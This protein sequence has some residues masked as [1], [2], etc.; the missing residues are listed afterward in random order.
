MNNS[1]QFAD[2]ASRSRNAYEVNPRP[3][4]ALG[5]AGPATLV[6][7]R[8]RRTM[9]MQFRPAN[10]GL[11]NRRSILRRLRL[12]LSSNNCNSP[13][14]MQELTASIHIGM[15]SH[16][17]GISKPAAYSS[18]LAAM[19]L[20]GCASAPVT[21]YHAYG[22][23]ITY[24]YSLSDP[25]TQAYPAL[26]AAHEQVS[27]VNYG[28]PGDQACDLP[29][30]QIFANK[31]NPTLATHMEYSVLVGTN[32]VIFKGT[33]AYESVFL[34]C[35]QAILSW[36]AIPAEYKTLANDTRVTT[37]GAGAINSPN[38]WNAWTTAGQGS[39]ISFPITLTRKGPIYA[40]PIISD[41]NPATYTYS[42]DG[43]V[44]GTAGTQTHPSI[45]TL[46]G[47]TDSLGFLRMGPVLP[48]KHLVTFTQT[49][50]GA[51]GVSVVGIGT[52]A[53]P[54]TNMMPTVLAGTITYQ[55][56]TGQCNPTSEEPCLQYN[57]DIEANE[58][59]FSA[60]GL[61]VRLFDTR[62]YMFATAA[63][64]NDALHPNVLG[65]I[66]LSH[67]LEASW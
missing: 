66:E 42:L 5:S 51:N 33:G 39:S 24:G 9:I 43:A 13:A 26:V 47:T 23:S 35:H 4:H 15:D 54:S 49:S 38:N 40:W 21:Q 19:M 14:D 28:S 27:F 57:Q 22:A 62:K 67:S 10:I 46:K 53:G 36:L 52:P 48:G 2:K 8:S 1:A 29:K 31:D 60:D 55:F 25:A 64:M 63:E 44:L 18:F 6:R 37:S 20:V 58:K 41:N 59:L 16:L 32:D 12:A 45:S 7:G 3:Y 65:Q 56:N 11:I 34:V 61:D 50:I 17:V 30:R